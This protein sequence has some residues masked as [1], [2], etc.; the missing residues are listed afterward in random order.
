V[1][2]PNLA[3]AKRPLPLREK[4]LVQKLLENLTFND[5]KSDSEDHGQHE[6]HNADCNPI[7]KASYFLSEPHLLT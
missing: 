5:D 2:Y 4:L 7:F 6:G 1:N 3:S